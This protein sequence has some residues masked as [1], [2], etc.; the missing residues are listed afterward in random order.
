MRILI[1][2]FLIFYMFL[3]SWA[4]AGGRSLCS[5][6]IIYFKNFIFPYNSFSCRAYLAC[7]EGPATYP[8]PAGSI[9]LARKVLPP[10]LFLRG[11]SGLPGELRQQSAFRLE[12]SAAYSFRPFHP[13][14]NPRAWPDR[15]VGDGGGCPDI[16]VAIFFFSMVRPVFLFF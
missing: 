16:R 10:I 14:K 3:F 9:W 1:I 6:F 12:S 13:T 11:S 2:S 15:V 7:P 8:F 4:K 5:R